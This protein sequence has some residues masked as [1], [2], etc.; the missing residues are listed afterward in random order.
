MYHYKNPLTVSV[1]DTFH[2]E[3]RRLIKS[4]SFFIADITNGFMD[5]SLTIF[6]AFKM[7]SQITTNITNTTINDPQVKKLMKEGT[8]DLAIFGYFISDFQFG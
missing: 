8:F 2:K 4:K 7:L 5:G 6:S 3:C 1:V